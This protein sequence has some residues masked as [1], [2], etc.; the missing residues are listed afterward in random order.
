MTKLFTMNVSDNF[1]GTAKFINEH[2]PEI[3]DGIVTMAFVG[4][5][6]VVVYRHTHDVT[7]KEL[8]PIA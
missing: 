6:T 1:H 7:E 3:V 2:H 5:I 8:K 4:Y